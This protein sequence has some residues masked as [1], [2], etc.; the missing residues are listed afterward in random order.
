M[1]EYGGLS[2]ADLVRW[3]LGATTP[4]ERKAAFEAI[5]DRHHLAVFR[6]CARWFP[7]PDQAQDVCQ[8]AFEA[9]FTLLAD[10]RGPERP[11]KLAGWLINIARYRGQEYR[12]R[13]KPPGVSWATLP[14]GQSLDQI[15]DD[16]EPRSGSAVR[17]AHAT[18]LVET[19]VATLTARQQEVYQLRIVGELTGRQ[20][21]E[22]LGISD[23]TASNE[24]TRVQDLIANGFGALILLQEGR[25]YCPDLARIIETAPGAVGTMAFTTVLREQIVR[26]F[27]NCNVCDDCRTCNNK[28]RE[29]V[30]AYAPALIPILFAAD[31]R[32]RIM[33][34]IN[35]ITR[36][37]AHSHPDDPGVAPPADANAAF[38]YNRA[39]PEAAGAAAVTAE[40]ALLAAGPH[41][42]THSGSML[43][44]TLRRRPAVSALIAL[45]V[46]AAVG[47]GAAA[48]ASGG[49]ATHS[50]V[51]VA[52]TSSGG[53]GA[54]Q[55]APGAAPGVNTVDVTGAPLAAPVL[56]IAREVLTA[57]RVHDSATLDRLLYP[58]GPT[59][60]AALNKLLAQP[61]IYAQIITLLTETHGVPQDG[62]TGWPGFL[63]AGTSL[64]LAVADLKALGV[65]SP[66]A[67][68]GIVI[69]IGAP[70]DVKPYIP[71]IYSIIQTTG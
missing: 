2:D 17:R 7:H 1:Q 5:T 68:K 25:R 40:A 48:L 9:A 49:G 23:K 58:G 11:D 56:A 62:F 39:V 66:Q 29:L 24:I 8:A 35:R 28:R 42:A 43:R 37:G 60:A 31:L 32:D 50:G 4:D 52:A 65:T 57:A 54:T 22:R 61:G 33:E 36:Q 53:P 21:A 38:A 64:P 59:T 6:Q 3:A 44:R 10:G 63:L 12:R 46:L 27:D 47:G 51:A 70:Y 34:V 55:T 20:V 16:E 19:V 67:Y 30:G 69:N 71:K 26:H 15:E 41:R 13:D 18:R 14:E 45:V